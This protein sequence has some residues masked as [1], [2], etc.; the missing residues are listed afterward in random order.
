MSNEPAVSADARKRDVCVMIAAKDAAATIGRAVRSAL[1]AERVAEVVVV[2]D[3]SADEETAQAARAADDGSG[4]LRI[5]RLARNRG[6][7]HA[8]NVAIER[9][10]AP[11]LAVLDADDWF[12]P[13]R[14]ASMLDGDDWDFVADNV[15]FIDSR[16]PFKEFEVPSFAADPGYLDTCAFVEGN[17]S[18]RG[19]ARGETGFLKPVMRR[20][21]LDRHGLRYNETLRL[22]ED[23]ELYLR[24]LARGAR[25]K[26]VRHCGYGAMVRAD[27]L[28]GRHATEDLKHLYEADEAIL[29]RGLP[30]AAAAAV[31]RHARHIRRRHALRSFL[32]RKKQAGLM[33][34]GL[35]ALARPSLFP[36]ILGGVATDKWAAWRTR[37]RQTDASMLPRFLMPGRPLQK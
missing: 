9:S 1:G 13:A 24:A 16:Q 10:R 6:P 29:A 31:R 30:D 14:F 37:R 3:G 19:A 18:R 8:R 36:A 34:A 23:Y 7:A 5:E 27:S 15:V 2:D 35:E 12:L 20:A 32:D 21:F 25:Y 33:T 28:S 4:R 17:I 11:F 22:G 26:V